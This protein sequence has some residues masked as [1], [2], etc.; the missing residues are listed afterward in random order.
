MQKTLLSL[1]QEAKPR[2]ALFTTYTFSVFW[3]ETFVLPT[4]RNCGCEQIDVLI[5]SREA[6]RSTEEATSLYAGTAYRVI[7]VEMQG[8][9]V[10]HPKLAYLQGDAYDSLVVGSGNLTLAGYGKNLEVLDAV[11]SQTSPGVFAEFGAFIGALQAAQDFSP[12]NNKVL[13]GYR[14]RAQSVHERSLGRD[15]GPRSVWLVHTME[16]P[17]ADQFAVLAEHIRNPE[18]LTVLSPYHSPSGA[19]VQNLA[20]VVGAVSVRIGVHAKTRVVPLDE[21]KMVFTADVGYVAADTTDPYRFPHAKCFELEGENGALVMAGSVNATSQSLESTENVEVSLVRF[22]KKSPFEWMDV[23]PTGFEAC[24]FSQ[25]G[26]SGK[27]YSLQATWTSGQHIVGAIAPAPGAMVVELSIWDG[28]RCLEVIPGVELAENGAFRVRMKDYFETE[29]ALRLVLRVDGIEAATWLNLDFALTADESERALLRAANRMRAGDYHLDD[30]E[31]IFKWLQ[32]LQTKFH[33]PPFASGGPTAGDS[34]EKAESAPQPQLSYEDWRNSVEQFGAFARS[35]DVA[36]V[37]LEAA[38]RWLNRDLDALASD[39]ADESGASQ[40]GK[41][42]QKSAPLTKG[43]RMTLLTSDRAEYED[44]GDE[45][46]EEEQRAAAEEEGK[47]LFQ[48]LIENLPLAL[49]RDAQSPIV[50]MMVELAGCAVLKRAFAHRNA[51]KGVLPPVEPLVIDVWLQQYAAF[52]YSPDNRERL[53][54]FFCAMAC[55]AAHYHD[56]SEW[57]SLKEA[58]ERLAGRVLAVGEMEAL[59]RLA[60]A[61]PRFLRV[62]AEDRE[63]IATSAAAVQDCTTL[64]AHLMS[65]L[66]RLCNG[67]QPLPRLDAPYVEVFRALRRALDHRNK[68]FPFAILRGTV[69]HCLCGFTLQY[70]DASALRQSRVWV[71]GS[72]SRPLFYE[73]DAAHLEQNGLAGRFKEVRNA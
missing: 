22:L 27:A 62:P 66:I 57:P 63:A 73:L 45:P 6:Q 58:I 38:F 69:S 70:G 42:K 52:P 24:D 10:F 19:P 17:A 3:F 32:G 36:R 28:P 50:P 26:H 55:C 59:A 31:A 13:D 21:N 49:A 71:C 65:L 54:P 51:V 64:S 8:S 39:A 47:S 34:R 60:L 53:L 35:A 7:P 56:K 9:A 68:P 40:S 12:Q 1:I 15:N 41:A 11:S 61:S 72:C 48:H 25:V 16:V 67:E 20:D 23:E 46:G 29:R 4:L 14:Q 2:R 18:R 30:I 37:S 43:R 44:E 33:A 5:D